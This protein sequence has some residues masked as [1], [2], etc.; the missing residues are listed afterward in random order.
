MSAQRTEGWAWAGSLPLPFYTPRVLPA[1]AACRLKRLTA[2]RPHTLSI[3]TS[4]F[5]RF[6]ITTGT[7]LQVFV[8]SSCT[9]SNKCF[10]AMPAFR[11]CYQ[12]HCEGVVLQTCRC[13]PCCQDD[14]PIRHGTGHKTN[15]CRQ[16]VKITG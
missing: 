8:I 7:P 5:K 2:C 15:G 3:K 16:Y 1:T 12:L 11:Y 14:R 6:L 9:C 13:Q 4:V 10:Q